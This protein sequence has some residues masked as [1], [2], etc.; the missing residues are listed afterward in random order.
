M[1]VAC[2]LT[3]C[4]LLLVVPS[5]SIN[6]L[7]IWC[8]N[9]IAMDTWRAHI[10]MTWFSLHLSLC[11]GRMNNLGL[12]RA[13]QHTWSIS[14]VFCSSWC[15]C[16]RCTWPWIAFWTITTSANDLS[17]LC[18]LLG[19]ALIISVVNLSIA[20]TPTLLSVLSCCILH[21]LVMALIWM[22]RW[23]INILLDILNMSMHWLSTIKDWFAHASRH[24]IDGD[25][26]LPVWSPVKCSVEDLLLELCLI[27]YHWEISCLSWF[28]ISIWGTHWLSHRLFL[29]LVDFLFRRP[30]AILQRM[31]FSFPLLL[32][33]L[34][35]SSTIYMLTMTTFKSIQM[36]IA[37]ILLSILL[38]WMLILICIGLDTYCSFGGL[39]ALNC[40]ILILH[41]LLYDLSVVQV[42]MLIVRIWMIAHNRIEVGLLCE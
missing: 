11:I 37:R 13:H 12:F 14:R 41:T 2:I 21:G 29:A 25:L 36:V 31:G 38:P 17:G 26:N 22:I 30:C 19:R 23:S 27:T 16:L 3:L 8:R 4:Q 24:W 10:C 40:S 5:L 33:D 39:S 34:F 18:I 35:R 1:F 7:W 32:I 28:L 9:H 15:F 20:V 6:T 42:W